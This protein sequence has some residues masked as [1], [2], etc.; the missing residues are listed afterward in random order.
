MIQPGILVELILAQLLGL[1]HN[2]ASLFQVYQMVPVNLQLLIVAR[3][4]QMPI[5]PV[6]TAMYIHSQIHILPILIFTV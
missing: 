3:D 2:A 4:T 6:I 5:V 1:A